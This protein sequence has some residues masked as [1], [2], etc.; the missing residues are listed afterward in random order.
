MALNSGDKLGPYEIAAP[1]GAG[2]MGEVYRARDTR[3]ERMV[4]AHCAARDP[5]GGV[6]QSS[7]HPGAPRHRFE[8]HGDGADRGTLAARIDKGPLPLD[9]AI[10]GART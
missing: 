5:D 9:Q 2:G 8:L 10:T 6:A 1:L 7:E 4:A 3:L